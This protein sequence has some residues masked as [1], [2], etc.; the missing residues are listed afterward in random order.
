ML[1][2]AICSLVRWIVWNDVNGMDKMKP[3]EMPVL[4]DSRYRFQNRTKDA[5]IIYIIKSVYDTL[6]L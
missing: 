3:L 5:S 6:N 4:I 1:N 2:H